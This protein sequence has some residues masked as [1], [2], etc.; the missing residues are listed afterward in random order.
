MKKRNFLITLLAML[1]VCVLLAFSASAEEKTITVTYND[2]NGVAYETATPNDDGT[3]TLRNDKRSGDGTFTFEDGTVIDKQFFGWFSQTGEIYMPGDTVSFD[4]STQLYEAYGIEVDNAELF[5]YATNTFKGIHYIRLTSSIELNKSITPDWAT[6]IIDLNGFSIT[7]KV[8]DR[9]IDIRRGSIIII[10]DGTFNHT[11][12]TV[13]EKADACFARIYCHGY[14]DW[15]HPQLCW[16][17]DG[18]R[19][20]TPYTFFW[21]YSTVGGTGAYYKGMPNVEIA[22]SINA[23]ELI[24]CGKVTFARCFIHPSAEITLSG[25]KMFDV[26]NAEGTDT[27]FT[28]TLDGS[29]MMSNPNSVAISDIMIKKFDIAING[30]SFSFSPNDIDNLR[31]YLPDNLIL[32]ETDRYGVIWYDVDVNDCEHN[33]IKNAELSV[34]ATKT[35]N[36]MDVFEC[37]NCDGLK[38][39]V[40]VYDPAEESINITVRD[41]KGVETTVSVQIKDILKYSTEGVGKNTIVVLTGIKGNDKYDVG[42]I[43]GIEIPFGFSKVQMTEENLALEKI[44]VLDEAETQICNL[45]G[46]KA[47]KTIEIGKATVDFYPIGA[48]DTLEAIISKTSGATVTFTKTC[49]DGKKNLKV[50]EMCDGSQYSFGEFSFRSTGIET[51]IFPDKATVEFAGGAAFYTSAVKYVYFGKSIEKIN[52]KPF[53][54]ANDLQLVIIMAAKSTSEY[55][56]CVEKDENATSRLVVYW[57]TGEGVSINGNTFANRKTLGV[58]LYVSDTKITSLSNCT[59]TVYSG[60][61]HSYTEGVMVPPTCISAGVWGPVTDCVCGK[62]KPATYTVYT[63]DSSATF[64][65]ETKELPISNEHTPSDN[66]IDIVYDNGYLEKGKWVS[67]CALCLTENATEAVPSV[68]PLFVSRGY[69]ISQY[70][71][72]RS[73]TQGYEINTEAIGILK[74]TNPYFSYGIVSMVNVNGIDVKPL[75]VNGPSVREN[76]NGVV[77]KKIVVAGNTYIDV[78]ITGISERFYDINFVLCTYTYDGESITYLDNGEAKSSLTGVKYSE[79]LDN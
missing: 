64:T 40:T 22:G 36:G 32:L 31:Y 26:T 51:V 3:Y 54:C 55:S 43:V 44:Y 53:D 15:D 29:I 28:L 49:F 68:N 72:T 5:T 7:S 38:K 61:P 13:S 12:E 2:Y 33:W 1:A 50:L 66:H 78:K 20:E 48:C 65:L 58:E 19:I 11:P 39:V 77:F 62:S 46:L 75:M 41:E 74:K 27:Y 23:K 45:S 14:G 79:L 18:V 42:K 59:Y 10:G 34:V 71:A 60:I 76:E 63:A 6:V 24:R 52:N 25:E 21:A 30:G 17:G 4:K 9:A 67:T 57:H 35:E 70:G 47:L 69:S 56:F 37:P 8:N 73:I 16:V